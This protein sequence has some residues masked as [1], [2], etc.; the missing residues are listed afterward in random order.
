VTLSRKLETGCTHLGPLPHMLHG[1]CVLAELARDS[2]AC[3]AHSGLGQSEA[4]L[5]LR[6]IPE[7]RALTM[8]P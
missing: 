6:L 3:P 4:C 8:A 2:M 7:R 1:T 5:L